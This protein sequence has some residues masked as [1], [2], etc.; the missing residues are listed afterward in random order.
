MTGLTDWAAAIL[1]TDEDILVPVKKLWTQYRAKTPGVSLDE[2]TRAL[3]QDARFEFMDGVHPTERWA[4]SPEDASSDEREGM[5]AS[6]FFSGPRVKMKDREITRDHVAKMVK[7]HTD[8]MLSAL[9]SAF[10][11][12]PEDLPEEA[13]QELLDLIA[14][15]KELQLDLEES[16]EPPEEESKGHDEKTP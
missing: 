9:W 1:E 13:Q 3:T 14:Q 16:L 5:E 7:K 8:N 10:D 12:R 2:F 6:G 15:A 4:E 11:V